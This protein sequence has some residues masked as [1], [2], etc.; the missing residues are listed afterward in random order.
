[1]VRRGLVTAEK[2]LRGCCADCNHLEE[3]GEGSRVFREGPCTE[4]TATGLGWELQN[5][6]LRGSRNNQLGFL[7]F[8]NMERKAEK[9][10]ELFQDLDFKKTPLTEEGTPNSQRSSLFPLF[11]PVI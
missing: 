2:R 7:Y 1:V 8:S 4:R 10:Q 9:W 6:Y 5:N 3:T 11:S